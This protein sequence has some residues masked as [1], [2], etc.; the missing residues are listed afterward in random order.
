MAEAIASLDAKRRC[1]GVVFTKGRQAFEDFIFDDETLAL[2]LEAFEEFF[3]LLI[4]SS[5]SQGIAEDLARFT[6]VETFGR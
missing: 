3:L 6:D 5:A 4:K 2:I 1:C